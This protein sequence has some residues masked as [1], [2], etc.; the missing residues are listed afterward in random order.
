M[1]F[2]LIDANDFVFGEDFQKHLLVE[3]EPCLLMI[4]DNFLKSNACLRNGLNYLQHLIKNEQ[5]IP[6][7][8][9]GVS[10]DNQG[11]RVKTPTEFEKVSNVIK[12]MNYWQ[13][14][15]LEL[16]KQKRSIPEEEEEA[17]VKQ[18]KVVTTQ[19]WPVSILILGTTRK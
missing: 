11:N 5:V 17:F 1:H 9:D 7:I 16:R 3:G 14:K 6:L 8:I 10:I 4:S 18:L 15:Y 2:N 13:E 19:W 12:Y